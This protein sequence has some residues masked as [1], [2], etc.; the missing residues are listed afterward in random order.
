[1][2]QA[3][4]SRG[5]RKKRTTKTRFY[6][7]RTAQETRSQITDKLEEYSQNYINR[8][9]QNGKERVTDL[10]DAP[11]KTL[12]AWIDDGKASITDL[13][14]ETRSKVG[15]LIKDG[16]AFLRKAGKE[17]RQTLN[18]VFDDGKTRIEDLREETR[19]RMA[20]LKADTR[21]LLTGIG[22]DARL[23][24]DEV[25][26]GGRQALDKIPGKKKVEIE[27]RSRIRKLPAQFNLPSKKDLDGLAR[28]VNR[29]NKKVEA[30]HQEVAA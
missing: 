9:I 5:T 30:L 7:I 26:S 21:S 16:K 15:D 2:S 6:V 23:L 3:K 29:L 11:F 17:P 20:E 24:V 14:Q 25:V 18:D 4:K 19:N 1:M 8:P 28:R 27:V 12:S 13:N 10:K 22:K